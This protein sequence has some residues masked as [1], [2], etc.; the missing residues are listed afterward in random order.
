MADFGRCSLERRDCCVA[1]FDSVGNRWR[2]K[3]VRLCVCAGKI[4]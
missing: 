1:V 4:S 2:G 3:K